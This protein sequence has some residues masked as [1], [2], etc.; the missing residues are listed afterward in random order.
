[1]I[2]FKSANPF[3]FNSVRI[4]FIIALSFWYTKST[5]QLSRLL[6]DS[7]YISLITVDPGEFMYSTFG[8]SAPTRSAR[9]SSGWRRWRP[10]APARPAT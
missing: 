7:A 9:S 5:A 10:T 4:V 8:H 6:S 3:V 1:M 2:T